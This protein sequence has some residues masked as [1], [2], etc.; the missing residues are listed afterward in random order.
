ML[1]PIIVKDRI[2]AMSTL[3]CDA[4]H[5]NPEFFIVEGVCDDDSLHDSEIVPGSIGMVGYSDNGRLKWIIRCYNNG[6][7]FETQCYAESSNAYYNKWSVAYVSS[8]QWFDCVTKT[9][10]DCI[11]WILFHLDELRL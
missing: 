2:F 8:E 1:E 11:P 9:T 4:K 3:E 5:S 10:P 6:S 7:C